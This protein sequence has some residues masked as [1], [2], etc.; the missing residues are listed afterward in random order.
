M[1]LGVWLLFGGATCCCRSGR[2]AGWLTISRDWTAIRSNLSV[3]GAI[4]LF[5]TH[6]IVHRQLSSRT[7]RV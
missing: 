1:A 6:L 3:N 4:G 5:S 2:N 7:A